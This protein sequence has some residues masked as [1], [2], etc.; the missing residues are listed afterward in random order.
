MKGLAHK[1]KVQ[2][3]FTLAYCPWRNGTV[4]RLNRDILQVMRVLLLE[5]KLAD[6]QW[7]Y[8]LPAVQANR[9]QTPVAS[10]A[11]KSPLEVFQGREPSTVMDLVLD[12]DRQTVDVNVDWSKDNIKETLL[13]LQESMSELHK[14]IVEK[15]HARQDK[16]RERTSQYPACNAERGNYVLWSR[17]D[18]AH[19]P[20][21][22]VT[23][24]GPYRVV[25]VNEF[26]A[27]IEHLITKEQR[28]AHMSRLKMYA[29]SSFEVTEEI[30]EH[31]ADQGILLKV[32]HIAAHKFDKNRDCYY[33]LVHWEGFESIEASWEEVTHLVR[34][35]PVVVQAYVDALKPGKDREQLGSRI[36]TIKAKL[37][38]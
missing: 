33:M 11:N 19:H 24:V 5:Y 13:K 14:E 23:W 18:E 4:E 27:R 29:E 21:L 38:A 37:K 10:L 22:L 17:V 36:K 2:H 6:H 9:N 34:D 30:L 8:L 20:K 3:E 25:E 15:N 32:E 7:D 31:V 28:D 12:E 1:F 26:S 35:C 16:A